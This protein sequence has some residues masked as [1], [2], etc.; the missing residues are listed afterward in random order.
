[1]IGRGAYGRPWIAAL[2][3]RALHHGERIVEPD[4]AERLNIILAHFQDSLCFYGDELGLKIFRKH[5]GWYVENAPVTLGA[6]A[7]R[8]AKS[9]LCRLNSPREVESGLTALW[10]Q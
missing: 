8:A 6:E 3:D 7:R 5:L 2:L 9:R 1:M 10:L 4:G